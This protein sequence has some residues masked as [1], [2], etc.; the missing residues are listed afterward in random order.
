MESKRLAISEF[1]SLRE[2]GHFEAKFAVFGNVDFD[3]DI[4]HSGSFT[5]SVEKH[6]LPPVVWSHQWGIPPVGV[7][8]DADEIDGGKAMWGKGALFVGDD[9]DHPIARQ[10]YTAMKGRDG[11]SALKEFSF[12]YDAVGFDLEQKDGKQIRNLRQVDWWE[13]GPTLKGANPQTELL[14]VKSGLIAELKAGHGHSEERLIQ[15][16]EALEGFVADLRA[17]KSAPPET[18]SS[19]TSTE[20]NDDNSAPNSAPEEVDEEARTRIARL[21]WDRPLIPEREH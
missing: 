19:T 4:L 16:I 1:K 14:A 17:T 6:G 3:D 21:L 9:D 12:G 20:R 7:T 2:P 15:A 13:W 5:K 18:T 11:R 8:L 10:V